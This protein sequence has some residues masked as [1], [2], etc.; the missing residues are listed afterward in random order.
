MIPELFSRRRHVATVRWLTSVAP[1]IHRQLLTLKGVFIYNSG[2][3][4][5]EFGG[6]I[7]IK[8]L[9]AKQNNFIIF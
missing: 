9:L 2:K 8:I 4:N 5:S 1:L 6:G 7:L 3:W